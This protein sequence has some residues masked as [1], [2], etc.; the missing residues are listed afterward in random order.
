MIV[1]RLNRFAVRKKKKFFLSANLEE[2]DCQVRARRN[3]GIE[4]QDS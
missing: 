2:R 1:G 3:R 4:D